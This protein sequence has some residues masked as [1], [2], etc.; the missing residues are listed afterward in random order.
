MFYRSSLVKTKTGISLVCTAFTFFV[1][2][3]IFFI[4]YWMATSP[5]DRCDKLKIT[6]LLAAT[7]IFTGFVMPRFV[8]YL[9]DI[10]VQKKI[11]SELDVFIYNLSNGTHI[12]IPLKRIINL[13][14]S[15]EMDSNFI[16]TANFYSAMENFNDGLDYLSKI[17]KGKRIK[18]STVSAIKDEDVANLIGYAK[19]ISEELKGGRDK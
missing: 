4:F 10:I 5:N 18:Y 13:A 17:A 12:D 6:L 14:R 7:S 15:L 8:L 3:A 11:S 2:L 9:N 16:R 19:A 1:S